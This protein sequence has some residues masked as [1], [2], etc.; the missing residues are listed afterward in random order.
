MS[1]PRTVSLACAALAIVCL[2]I[3]VFA[4]IAGPAFAQQR[5]SAEAALKQKVNANTVA[6]LGGSN[7][8]ASLHMAHD[9]LRAIGDGDDLRILPVSGSGGLQTVRDILY[10]QDKDIGFINID[11]LNSLKQNKRY[12]KIIDRTAYISKLHNEEFHLIS[13][14]KI[15]SVQDLK[16]KVVAFHGGGSLASGRLLLDSLKIKPAKSIEMPMDEAA[17]RIKSGEVDAVLCV[18]GKPFGDLEHLLKLNSELRLVP[19]EY[20]EPLQQVYLPATLTAEDYPGLVAAGQSVNTV[21]IGAVLAV[22][23]LPPGTDRYRRLEKFVKAFFSKFDKLA[24]RKDR[25]P[26]W[27]EVNLAARLPGWQRFKPAADWLA[28]NRKAVA[29]QKE[30]RAQFAE[31]LE[32]YRQK[33]PQTEVAPDELFKQFVD[34]QKSRG[35]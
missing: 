3:I 35:R 17:L 30:L 10:L 28:A 21:A 4:Q 27:S 25:H 23:N 7:A 16:G 14:R 18:T 34:W 31:F 22:N 19:I 8:D 6:I 5:P 20:A 12:K 32:A 11:A 9:I 15:T 26:K 24:A 1:K 33:D 2:A 29:T 13:D